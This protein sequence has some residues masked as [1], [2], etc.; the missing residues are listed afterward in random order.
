MT[1]TLTPSIDNKSPLWDA[2][3][4]FG[5]LLVFVDHIGMFIY[6]EQLWLRAVGRSAMPVFLFLTGFALH[7]RQ[8]IKIVALGVILTGLTIWRV[9]GFVLNM[10]LTIS[11]CRWILSRADRYPTFNPWRYWLFLNIIAVPAMLVAEY[12][13]HAL[14]IAFLGYMQRRPQRFSRN[15][16]MAYG[17]LSLL[18]YAA[19]QS[20][21]FEITQ[22]AQIALMMLGLCSIFMLFLNCTPTQAD[23]RYPAAMTSGW[24]LLR[25]SGKY[26]LYIYA[27]HLM[28]LLVFLPD[29]LQR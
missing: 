26:C 25:A 28:L 4:L 18:M 19:L 21:I 10:L 29:A 17:G 23:K 16:R 7:F 15:S 20:F 27:L 11:F 24:K 6:P 1:S 12:G 8:D 14:I 9:D 2:L 3:K 13:S 22:P 5:L